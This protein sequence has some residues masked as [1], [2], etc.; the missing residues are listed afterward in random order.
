MWTKQI[1][2]L[3]ARGGKYYFLSG[4]D[5]LENSFSILNL[6]QK[7]KFANYWFESGSPLFLVKLI[8]KYNID[9]PQLERDKTGE[10]IFSSY[11]INRMH[12]VSLLFQT[13]YL[14][15]KEIVP[16]ERRKRFY[17][18]SYPNE[19]V[20]EAFLVDLLGD[21]SPG[22]SDKISVVID[23]LKTSLESGDMNRFFKITR[24]VF[25]SIPYDIFIKDR[26]AYY[27]TV[28][29]IILM[30]IGISIE[31]E[32][33]TNLGRIDAVIEEENTIYIMEFKLGTADE[34]LNQIKEKKYY[35]KYLSSP[36]AIKLVG[37]GFDIEQRNRGDYKIEDLQIV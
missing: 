13:G 10:E 25:A 17:I 1:N 23:D 30:L 21:L 15:I 6:F 35:E 22:F 12:V 28:I 2:D 3:F 16:A 37:V 5:A 7:G 34:A 29:Y 31:P 8:E 26:E 11:D 27:H 20:K 19:E 32:D 14:T 9:L 36:K 18:L 24:S 33:E 4:R